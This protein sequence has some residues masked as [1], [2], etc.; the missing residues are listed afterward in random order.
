[1]QSEN[2]HWRLN[3]FGRV[4]LVGDGVVI[5]NFGTARAAK[6]LVLFSLSRSGEMS[7]ERL[8]DLVWPDD[9]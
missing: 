4:E 9:D 3:L 7:R 8:A 6:L 1:M 5:S 2:T